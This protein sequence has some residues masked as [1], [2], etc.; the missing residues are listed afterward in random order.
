MLTARLG[1]ALARFGLLIALALLIVAFSALRPGN[2]PTWSNAGSILTLAAPL[3]I[4]SAGL[5][6]LLVMGDFDLSIGSMIGLGGAACVVLQSRWHLTWESATLL[7]LVL[8][9]LVGLVNGLLTAYAQLS[10]FIV[11]LGMGTVL[12]GLEFS[13]TGQK[14]IYQGIDPGYAKLGQS[15]LLGLNIQIWV[16]AALALCVWAL[17][18]HTEPGRYFYAIGSNPVASRLSGIRVELLRIVGFVVVSL[19]ATLAGVLLTAQAD[20]SFS[21]AGTPYLLPAFASAF[22]GTT[23]FGAGRFNVLGTL[24]GV[25]LLGVTETGLTMLQLSTAA[26]L[27]VQGAV[28]ITAILLSRMGAKR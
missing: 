3:A 22:L 4:V 6:T 11:T 9:A 20:S 13:M 23:V 10:S 16:A 15:S 26:V 28:L 2:F 17:L 24:V 1:S 5:T 19:S 14:T 12:T 27:L 8:G 21:N 25:L 7:T 18:T